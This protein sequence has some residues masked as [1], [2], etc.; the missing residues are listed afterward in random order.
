[1]L[2][3]K[4]NSYEEFD[5]EKKIPAAQKFPTHPSS[6]PPPIIFLMVRPLGQTNNESNPSSTE[7]IIF[8]LVCPGS[9]P[10]SKLMTCTNVKLIIYHIFLYPIT[11]LF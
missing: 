3:P 11:H 2:Q 1:M 5:N 8:P 9:Y 10:W 7:P 6:P 4:K